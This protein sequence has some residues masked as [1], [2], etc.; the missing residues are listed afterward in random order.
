MDRFEGW[1]FAADAGRRQVV[2][3]VDGAG[4][5][6][7]DAAGWSGDYDWSQVEVSDRVGDIPRRV[8]LPD[9]R[10][11]ESGD[12]DAIDAIEARL[13]RGAGAA[14]LHLIE[15]RWR[16][17]AAATAAA[18]LIG[19]L[20]VTEG[21]PLLARAVAFALPAASLDLVSGQTL[22]A[23]DRLALKPT[24]LKPER[25]AELGRDLAQVA[26]AAGLPLKLAPRDGGPAIGANAFA[27]P[28]GTIVVTDQ[29]VRLAKSD[30]EIVAVLAHEAGHVARRHG[31]QRVMQSAV[32][33]SVLIFVTGD[34]S[35]V[36]TVAAALPTLLLHAAYSR[37]FEREADA[38][39]V[40]LLPKIGVEP[41]RLADMLER[42]GRAHRGEAAIGWLSSHPATPERVE[43]IRNGER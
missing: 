10:V 16:W 14:F 20:L 17:A 25:V 34:V 40:A 19:W 31:M 38:E 37:D 26:A 18:L 13:R 6:H 39:A 27:L 43:A 42:L 22:E 36:L 24:A 28:D 12:N 41:G 7:L 35:Q 23:L 5:L 3:E 2:A 1:L 21:V 4:R 15:R 8:A 29:L 32:I 11:I 30:D 9:G 33:G